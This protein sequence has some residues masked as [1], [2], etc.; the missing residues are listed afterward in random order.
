[1]D[2][3]LH[4]A[5]PFEQIDASLKCRVEKWLHPAY[6][7]LCTRESGLTEDEAERL[8]FRRATA[9]WRIR[10]SLRPLPAPQP[11]PRPAY[12]R[13]YGHYGTSITYQNPPTVVKQSALAL[14]QGEE[15]LK[16]S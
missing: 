5:N 13:G 10:E 7:A 2:T 11:A 6:D 1:M 9:I 4:T 12:N 3:I 16:Y 8:G 15:A 14:V